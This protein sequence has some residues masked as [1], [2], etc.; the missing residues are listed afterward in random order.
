MKMRLMTISTLSPS[1]KIEIQS[2]LPLT[3]TFRSVY[4]SESLFLQ[5]MFKHDATSV[6]TVAASVAGVDVVAAGVDNVAAGVAASV[7]VVAV[8]DGPIV[9]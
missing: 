8:V 9:A 3:K 7:S 6:S 5:G 4:M 1:Y 2:A